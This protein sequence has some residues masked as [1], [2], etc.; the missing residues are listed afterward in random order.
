M[1]RIHETKQLIARKAEALFLKN[2]FSD[3]TMQDIIN[4]IGLSK[5]AIYHHF[6]SK[7]EILD[8]IT[9]H[10][11]QELVESIKAITAGKNITLQK[12]IVELVCAITV[13]PLKNVNESKIWFSR[14]PFAYFNE[15]K[16]FM[17]SIVPL[18]TELLKQENHFYSRERAE[19]IVV[20]V[21]TFINT[22]YANVSLQEIKSRI[23]Y[24]TFQLATIDKSLFDDTTISKLTQMFEHILLERKE[25][26]FNCE[27]NSGLGL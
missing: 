23:Q 4:E 3:T 5:G 16:F 25:G 14:I 19:S 11:R 22:V 21:M 17:S 20:S 18:L 1:E 9:E 24:L 2:G 15:M 26:E 27:Q 6:K 8:W 12:K 7:K 10:R 13:F